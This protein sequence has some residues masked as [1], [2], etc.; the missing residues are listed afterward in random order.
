MSRLRFRDRLRARNV[1]RDVWLAKKQDSEVALRVAEALDSYDQALAITNRRER[2]K[3][4]RQVCQQA[5][6]LFR[7]SEISYGIDPATVWLIIQIILM[8]WKWW[9]S[10]QIVDPP[11]VI[12]EDEPFMLDDFD[13][14]GDSDEQNEP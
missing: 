12:D 4:V 8:I 7:G 5:E 13:D 9:Q 3:A 10:R 6:P 11:E 14:E 1:G 2:R